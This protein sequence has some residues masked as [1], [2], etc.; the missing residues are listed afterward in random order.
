MQHST[1]TDESGNES[2]SVACGYA[3][4]DAYPRSGVTL[5]LVKLG[6]DSTETFDIYPMATSPEGCASHEASTATLN[7]AKAAF[8]A[9]GLDIS[10]KP[11]PTVPSSDGRYAFPVN[12]STVQVSAWTVSEDQVDD[13]L[14]G[15]RE[16]GLFTTAGVLY[17]ER[18]EYQRTGAGQ[19]QVTFPLAWVQGDQ[20]VFLV[21]S[22]SSDMRSGA[23][24]KWHLTPPVSLR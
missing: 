4:M 12:G 3:G 7:R 16:S 20:A 2:G 5:A 19:L 13:P 24:E 6:E 21:R 11:A 22:V 17:V 18:S 9:A 10:K 23:T 1:F 8:E 15:M 14:L